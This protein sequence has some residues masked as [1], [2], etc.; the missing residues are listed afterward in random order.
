MKLSESFI[1]AG[2]RL[3]DFENHVPAPYL[4]K[5]F[6]LDFKP[7]KAEITICGLGFYELHI[8]GKDVT[9]GPLAPYISNPDDICYYDN[10][11]ITDLLNE[12]AN[13]IGILL[14]NGFRNSFGG[15]I[16]NFQNAHC[17]GPVTV[18]LCLEASDAENVFEMEADETFKTH[19]SPVIFDDLRMG[20]HYDA[21]REIPGWNEPGFDDSAWNNAKAEKTPG[22]KKKLCDSDPIVCTQKRKPV[23]IKHYDVLPFGYRT[24]APG[25]E[26]FESTIR[27]NVYVYDFGVN[28]AGLTVLHINGR[29]GQ[30]IVIRHGEEHL[31][32]GKFSVNTT[33]FNGPDCVDKYLE[34]HQTD[35]YIC[36]GGEEYFVPKFKYDG[37]RYAY[38]EGLEEDQAIE[39][40]L[41]AWVMNSDIKSRAGFVSSDDTLNRLQ[42]MV[43]RSDLAN[44]YYFP[45]DCPHREKNGWT[46]D[47]SV[48]SEH[49]MLNLHAGRSLKEWM[50]NI[51]M[52]QAPNGSL[53]G[54][55]PTGGWGF[56]WGNGPAWD[57]VC[58]NLPYYVYKYTGDKS[59]IQENV[60]MIMRYLCYAASRRDERGLVAIG[61]NDWMDP[62]VKIT[63]NTA[64]PLVF[65]DTAELHD[66][67]VK[68]AFLFGEI[69][70]TAE[71]NY[72]LEMAQMYRNAIRTHLI[73]PKT[74]IV[75]GN[76]QTSQAVA[77]ETGLFDADEIEEAGKR[78]VEIIHRD[79]DVNA[80]GMIGLRYIFHA[81]TRIGESELAYHMITS[82]HPHCYGYWVE[83]GATSMWESFMQ[84]EDDDANSRNHHFLGDVSSWMIQNVA[85]IKPNPTAD[86]ISS[87]EIS[88]HYLKELTFA[89]GYYE[90]EYGK[91]SARWEREEEHI[92]LTVE[93]P[94][95]MKGSVVL[96]DGHRLADG[97]KNIIVEEGLHIFNLKSQEER[98]QCSETLT[99]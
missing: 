6:S 68:A 52:A 70:C 67:S 74:R 69:G 45:T 30:K 94:A 80:C 31:I 19:D 73:D 10:Y 59:I 25:S 57:S 98:R 24:T 40:A 44:F 43:R 97:R 34:Y 53:P 1:K 14:G 38:V 11:D 79:G 78:L 3:C 5:E 65:T 82:R 15:F 84:M 12:G 96:T 2:D 41:T 23:E 21:R 13:V 89:E 76:C 48:S 8:N 46:G 75:A 58:V 29:P 36:K 85:G 93:V 27:E 86:D 17:R 33:I 4:R 66:I 37:F 61:L 22:G 18:A 39:D 9:K 20:C 42:D 62:N 71:K 55:V 91:L 56:A 95:G 60:F 90:N 64:S 51:R 81:L 92:K 47:A 26:P 87:F 99:E 28:T 50:D 7:T 32:D 49:M 63:K 83:N 77:I 16:W 72:A 35:V 54:I 88:P